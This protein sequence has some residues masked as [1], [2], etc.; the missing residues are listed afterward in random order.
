MAKQRETV[1]AFMARLDHPLKAEI[2][3][4]RTLILGANAA[5]TEQVKWNAPSFCYQGDDRVTLKLHPPTQIQLIFHRGA[6][7]K[8]SEG[9]NF[10]D[11]SGLVKWVAADR[12][13]VT[14]LD[15]EDIAAKRTQ[16]AALV[17]RWMQATR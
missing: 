9:F 10:D 13:I 15:R 2:E 5:I 16:L 8:D 4:V 6:T 1:D 3:A 17:D 11:E 14:L 7:V 12:G